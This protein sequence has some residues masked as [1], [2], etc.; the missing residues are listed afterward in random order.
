M[1]KEIKIFVDNEIEKQKLYCNK[2]LIF[3]KM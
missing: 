3:K 1:V 2:N